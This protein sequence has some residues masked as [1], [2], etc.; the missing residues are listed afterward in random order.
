MQVVFT[1]EKDMRYISHLDLMRL[2]QRAVRRAALPVTITQGF[3]PHY[4]IS[5]SRALKLGLESMNEDAVFS[6]TRALE[7]AEFME[8]LNN[9]LPE[10]VQVVNAQIV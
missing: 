9:K 1:K 10:G 2:F 3:S 5:V 8:R 6:L 7:P 4:K